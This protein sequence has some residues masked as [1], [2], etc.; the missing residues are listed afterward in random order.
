LIIHAD[1]DG[2]VVV[3]ED[4]AVIGDGGYLAQS[5][6]LHREHTDRKSLEQTIYTVY[7]AKRYAEG[8]RTVGRK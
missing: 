3:V 2:K 6:L 8:S 7:E 5:V 4:F 1:E